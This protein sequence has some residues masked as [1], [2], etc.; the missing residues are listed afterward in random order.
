MQCVKQPHPKFETG[1]LSPF[2]TAITTTPRKPSFFLSLS[3][4]LSLYIYIYI[5][6]YIY[7]PSLLG[8]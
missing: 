4:S 6:I 2:L 8:L 5:Y 3:L 7:L 1:S